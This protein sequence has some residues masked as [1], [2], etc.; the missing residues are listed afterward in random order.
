MVLHQAL[1]VARPTPAGQE[2][3]T[4]QVVVAAA[5]VRMNGAPTMVAA[6]AVAAAVVRNFRRDA[7]PGFWVSSLLIRVSFGEKTIEL[8]FSVIPSFLFRSGLRRSGSECPLS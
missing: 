2:V 8:S 7:A 5:A 4:F 3:C 1:N 6:P